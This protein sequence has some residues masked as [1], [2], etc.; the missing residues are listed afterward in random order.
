MSKPYEV[1]V[2]E[3]ANFQK[4]EVGLKVLDL[5]GFGQDRVSV[6]TKN[7]PE[8]IELAR[9]RRER[10][11]QPDSAASSG[12]GAALAAGAAAP[13]AI[14]TMLAPFFLIGPL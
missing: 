13:L 12:A 5:R 3:Y 7:D 14:G 9:T 11:E 8:L 6:I 2:A 4:A 1:V 10:V